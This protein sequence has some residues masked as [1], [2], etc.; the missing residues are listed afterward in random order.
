MKLRFI[1]GTAVFLDAAGE[2][3]RCDAIHKHDIRQGFLYGFRRRADGRRSILQGSVY[4]RLWTHWARLGWDAYGGRSTS[5]VDA[6]LQARIIPD[7]NE[8]GM[9]EELE[10]LDRH[11]GL[12]LDDDL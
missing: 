7:T 4:G 6:A 9:V 5:E 8:P 11:E 2:R 1:D 10:E 12:C 3:R